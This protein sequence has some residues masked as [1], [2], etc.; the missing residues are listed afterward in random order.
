[1]HTIELLEQALDLA[2]RLGYQIRQEWLDGVAG[3]GCVLG[4]RKVLFLDLALGPIDQLE[5]VLETL[6][7]EPQAHS[8]PM[9]HQL[10]KLLEV[11]KTA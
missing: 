5:A 1:M 6:R 4:G 9:P 3:G 2:A 11:R 8:L 10:R 7:R